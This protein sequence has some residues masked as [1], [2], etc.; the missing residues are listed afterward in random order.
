MIDNSTFS[1]L[2]AKFVTF[3][4]K[5]NFAETSTMAELLE[6]RGV[7]RASNNDHPD[8]IVIN[9]CSVTAVADKKC[10][11]MIRSLSRRHPDAIIVITGCYAQLKPEEVKELPG[12]HIVMGNE[13]KN[14]L[15]DFLEQYLSERKEK[16]SVIPSKKIHDFEPSCSHGDRTRYFLKIQD[17]CDY[18]CSYCTIPYARGRSRSP[19][20]AELIAQ[21][22]KVACEG[23]KEIVLTGVNIGDFRNEA[24]E[25]FLDL[26]KELDKVKGI[27]RYRIS[28]IEPNLLTQEIIEFVGTSN[29]FMPHFHIPL[30][31]G[32][33]EVLKLM[34]RRYDVA[35]F[36]QRVELI[37]KTIPN[38]FIG[39]DLIVGMRG[40]TAE[41]FDKS[42]RFIESLPISRLHL[43]PYSERQGTAALRIE[44]VVTPSEQRKRMMQ[45]DIISRQKEKEFAKSFIGATLPV[46]FERF[47]DETGMIE[48][49][50]D[51]YLHIMTPSKNNEQENNI[52]EVKVRDIY[53]FTKDGV[54]LSGEINQ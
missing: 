6:E 1:T 5:L 30:Q 53:S 38:A 43:F 50:T 44:P 34:R 16:I 31:S 4:C 42:K 20:I 41:R 45:M 21:A 46:L 47:D 17:G 26:I 37:R 14:K 32:D 40:E 25:T 11:Q 8:I 52:C 3:G 27:E 12:V 10:R 28:S 35:L 2:T 49:H 39:V 7:V 51:N 54:I 36:Q 22:E 24:G 9:T 48:G 13:G 33:N 18:F 19:R 29:K 23:G 15:P